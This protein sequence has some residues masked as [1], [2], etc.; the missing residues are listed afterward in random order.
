MGIFVG[1][2]EIS[3]GIVINIH[4]RHTNLSI[5]DSRLYLWLELETTYMRVCFVCTLV[6]LTA[7]AS[8]KLNL[9]TQVT[10]DTKL[11]ESQAHDSWVLESLSTRL[12]ASGK[13]AL[14]S[15]HRLKL[16]CTKGKRKE[17]FQQEQSAI[18]SKNITR[19][20]SQAKELVSLALSH[21]WS[22]ILDPLC[23]YL[24]WAWK[25]CNCILLEPENSP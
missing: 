8:I 12:R 10:N 21:N 18:L 15:N 19:L 24:A 17:S 3:L 6:T 22:L 9:P 7:Y 4:T 20:W 1:Q 13:S 14:W 25:Q 11:L 5:T 16:T 23:L 2:L